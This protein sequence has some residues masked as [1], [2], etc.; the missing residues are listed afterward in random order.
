MR[1]KFFFSLMLML[2][3]FIHVMAQQRTITGTVT[4]S[5][6]GTPLPDASIIVVG[7]AKGTMTNAAGTFSLNVSS[8]TQNNCK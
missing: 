3:C 2:F 1:S 7:E 5:K 8:K 6:D 4:N